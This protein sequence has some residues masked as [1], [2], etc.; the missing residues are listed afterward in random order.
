M[1]LICAS[2]CYRGYAE[3]EVAAT[4][5]SAPKLGYELM[6][7]HGPV[8]WSLEA[9]AAFDLP[10]RKARVEASGMKCVGL[11]TLGWGG[12]DAEDVRRRAHALTKV[13]GFAEALG[14]HHA[15]TTPCRTSAMQV[16]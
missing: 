8:L 10:A 14:C 6:E 7:I 3:D 2:I 16:G 5:E 11:H 15:T 12:A 1:D 13:V 9:A 4:L